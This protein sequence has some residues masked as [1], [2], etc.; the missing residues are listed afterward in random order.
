MI[1]DFEYLAPKTV[2]EALLFLTKYK[3]SKIIA[4]GQSLL[5]ILKQKLIMPDYLIDIKNL[6]GLDYIKYDEDTGLK[7]GALTVH[8]DIEKSPIIKQKFTV[9][10]E[11]E[12]NVATVQTRNWGTIGGN[13]CHADPAG[14]PA[15]VFAVLNAK[16]KLASSK[17]ERT[18][19]MEKFSKGYL[20]TVLRHNEML[21]EIQV[22]P[23]PPRTG[24]AQQKLMVMKGDMGTVGAAVSITLDRDNVCQ[25]ARIVLSN[26]AAVPLRVK[27]AEKMLVGKKIND[28]LLVEAGE[29]AAAETSPSADV[30]GSV[31]YRREMAK[32]F[33]RRVAQVALARALSV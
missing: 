12:N 23:I 25:N 31:E 33:V 7:I 10:S 2:E 13:I 16:L 6:P 5:V 20:E 4:G 3:E 22:P 18:V 24:V 1:A 15:P 32:V 26:V 8:R 29:A 30:H 19:A 17:G 28:S 27:S 14:D 21:I 9:L 11:M